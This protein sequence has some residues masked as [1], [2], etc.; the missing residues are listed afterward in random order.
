MEDSLCDF[1]LV[2]ISELF[3]FLKYEGPWA[4]K[5]K[6]MR[7]FGIL[8]QLHIY[9]IHGTLNKVCNQPSSLSPQFMGDRVETADLTSYTVTHPKGNE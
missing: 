4:F 3:M 1:L 8:G 2:P 6:K 9:D 5:K 7:P